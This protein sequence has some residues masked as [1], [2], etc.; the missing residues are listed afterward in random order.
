LYVSDFVAN[1]VSMVRAGACDGAVGDGS[2]R[3]LHAFPVGEGPAAMAFDQVTRTLYVANLYSRTVS[4]VST[5]RCEAVSQRGCPARSAAGTAPVRQTPESCDPEL[6]AYQSGLPAG[7]FLRSSVRVA[8]GRAG[9]EAWSLR[10]RRGV[11]APEGIEQGGLV[12]GGRWYPLC[13]A[14]LNGA[15]DAANV[16]LID[17]QPHGTVYGYIQHPVRV[18]PV[19]AGADV[20]PHP[21]LVAFHGTTFFIEALPRPACAYH[22]LKLHGRT[23]DWS[24]TTNIV[25]GGCEPGLPVYISQLDATWGPGAD[26]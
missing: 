19:L 2:C 17:T 1:T 8:E 26:N 21:T 5:V 7:P 13:S 15:G 22:S 9:G 11:R 25:F 14:P 18:T 10:A 24:G 23:A 4:R 20:P 6:A 16:E 3:P 12:I